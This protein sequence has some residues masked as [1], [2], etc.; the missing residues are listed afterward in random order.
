M[1]AAIMQIQ[2]V[3]LWYLPTIVPLVSSSVVFIYYPCPMM[4]E[5][6]LVSVHYRLCL[7]A[8]LHAASCWFS[9]CFAFFGDSQSSSAVLRYCKIMPRGELLDSGVEH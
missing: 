9:F 2:Y 3:L 5:S 8:S 1:S 6:R 7:I 4:I